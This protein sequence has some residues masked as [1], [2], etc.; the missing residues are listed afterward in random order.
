MK[1]ITKEQAIKVINSLKNDIFTVEFVKKNGDL[2]SM[3]CRL[4]VTKHLK[5]G[6]QAYEPSD[7]DL[8]CVFDMKK[9]AYRSINLNTLK[10]IK[11]KGEQYAVVL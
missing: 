6:E 9:Q 3:N 7:Y 11:I 5:G 4:G 10:T 1:K 2:R 8:V